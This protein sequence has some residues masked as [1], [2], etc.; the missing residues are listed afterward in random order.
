MKANVF[1]IFYVSQRFGIYNG[2]VTEYIDKFVIYEFTY[3][4]NY[5][6]H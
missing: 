4:I 2:I 6:R 5:Y 3:I 1:A